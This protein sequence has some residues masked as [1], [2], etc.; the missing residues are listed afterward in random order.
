MEKLELL[1]DELKHIRKNLKYGDI[2]F[3]EIESVFGDVFQVEFDT[4]RNYP[5]ESSI[6][7]LYNSK[8]RQLDYE[9][10]RDINYVI[11]GPYY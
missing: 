7:F 4:F 9:D 3:L 1:L 10:I 6:Q 5:D 11:D 2:L 8:Y